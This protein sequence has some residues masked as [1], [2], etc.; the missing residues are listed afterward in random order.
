MTRTID[1][2]QHFWRLGHFDDAWLFDPA[3]KVLCAD[4]VPADLAPQIEAAGIDA[5]IAVQTQHDVEETRWMLEL[6]SANDW[7]AGVV[8]WVDLRSPDCA[9]QLDSLA[10]DSKFVGVRHITQDEPDPDFIDIE[11]ALA[12]RRSPG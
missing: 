2:H 9:Q 1:A 4:H 12:R 7:I 6:A 5:T 3:R 11:R 8:G 10:A